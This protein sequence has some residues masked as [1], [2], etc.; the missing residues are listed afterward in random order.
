[1]E[2]TNENVNENTNENERFTLEDAICMVADNLGNIS[3]PASVL[4]VLAPEQILMVKQTIIDPVELARRN[5]VEILNA[6]HSAAEMAAQEREKQAEQ[7]EEM[8]MAVEKVS[9]AD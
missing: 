2:N 7:A 5:L 3:F 4:A 6:Y 9:I 1:M 8:H